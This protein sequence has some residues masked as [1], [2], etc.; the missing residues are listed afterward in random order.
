MGV[1]RTRGIKPDL[2]LARLDR[3]YMEHDLDNRPRPYPYDTGVNLTVTADGV[4]NTF[5]GYSQLIPQGHYD[6]GDTPNW[7]AVRK[8]LIETVSANDVYVLEFYTYDGDVTY[9][10]LGAV[11]IVRAALLPRSWPLEV[12][13]RC[14]IIDDYSLQARLKC[15]AGGNNITV[16]TIVQRHL[17]TDYHVGP[18]PGVWPVG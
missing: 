2:E 7:L 13:C 16:S 6:F 17:H 8:L 9:E 1:Y 14:F 18:S 5:G 4:A 15:A 12:P 11:R 3:G 10:P